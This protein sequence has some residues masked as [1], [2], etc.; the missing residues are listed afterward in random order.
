MPYIAYKKFSA[1]FQTSRGIDCDKVNL[2]INLD[3]PWDTET[4]FHRI[5]RAGRFGSYGMAISIISTGEEKDRLKTIEASMNRK[6]QL[7]PGQFLSFLVYTLIEEI[8]VRRNLCISYLCEL[9]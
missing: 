4:Y 8:R 6:I 7:L 9:I 5:G 2:V 1:I 3:L